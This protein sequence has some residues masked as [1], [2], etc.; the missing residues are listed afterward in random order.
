MGYACWLARTLRLSTQQIAEIRV[1]SL[2]H[3]IGKTALPQAL[4]EKTTSLTQNDWRQIR[5][6]PELGCALARAL[7]YDERIRTLIRHHHEHWD[8]TGY[9]YGLQ[10]TD[11]PVGARIIAIADVFDA[12]TSPRSYRVALDAGAALAVMRAETGTVLD[13]HLFAVFEEIMEDNF[14]RRERVAAHNI[15]TIAALLGR[16]IVH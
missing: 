16:S 11:T 9:P 14:G 7:G 5:K 10:E 15:S 8:G 4:L 13:P 1:A 6:H 3:D 2:L 12:L